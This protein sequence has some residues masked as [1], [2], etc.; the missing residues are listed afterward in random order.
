M[1]ASPLPATLHTAYAELLER[2][3]LDRMAQEFP[4]GGSFY[5]R[6]LRGKDYWYFKPGAAT[7]GGRRR[8]NYVGRDTAELREKIERHGEA[9]AAYRERRK[10]VVALERAGIRGPDPTTGRVLKA[11]AEAGVFRLRAVVI[12][13]VAY[14]TFSGLLGCSLSA[15]NAATDDLDIAQFLSVSTDVEDAVEIPFEKILKSVDDRFR[16]L[17]DIKGRHATRYVL[18]DSGYRVDVLT[19]NRGS[20][21]DD[22]VH[23]PALLTD[24]QP[25]RFLFL[26]FLIHN[27][28]PAVSLYGDGI[29]INV[30]AP[31]RYA[32]HKLLVSRLRTETAESQA[33]A[34]K[35]LRQL[36]EILVEKRPYEIHD[37]WQ[38]LVERGPKWRK[39]A[40]EAVSLLDQVTR[41][42]ALRERLLQVTAEG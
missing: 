16:A 13:S 17:P 29:L 33:K 23:L 41:T 31:E 27:E 28:V 25:L 39:Y 9:K 40:T 22:P 10:L 36:L 8:D 20:D 6:T 24:G 14:Q 12:G 15:R 19:P 21:T 3:A 18:G 5:K 42:S 1:P 38:D 30:P 34:E 35:D 37:L 32:L 2:C 7:D 4:L 26:D 11:L